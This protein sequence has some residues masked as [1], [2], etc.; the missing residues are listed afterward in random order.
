MNRYVA[1]IGTALILEF[2]APTVWGLKVSVPE[3]RRL[4]KIVEEQYPENVYIGASTAFQNL[5]QGEG[6]ILNREFSYITPTN[7]FK[8]PLIHPEPGKWRW[9]FPDGWVK[10]AEKNGQLIRMHAPISPQC[11]SWAKEDSRTAEELQNNLEEY[12]TALC[13]RYNGK[14]VIR[15]LDVVNETISSDGTW[16]GPRTGTNGWENPWLKI[17]LEKQIPSKFKILSRDGVPHYI[18]RAFE[19]ANLYAPDVKLIINQH[20]MIEPEAAEK[21]KELVLYLRGRGLRVDGVGWQAHLKD[22]EP[23]MDKKGSN[24]KVLAGL[25]NWAHQNHLDFLVTENNI[26][27]PSDSPYDAEAVATV[28]ENMVGTL[29]SKRGTG[30]VAWNLWSIS[31]KPHYSQKNKWVLGLWDQD[32]KPQEAYYRIQHLLEKA[33]N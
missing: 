16:F 17:G 10:S 9:D 29:I 19:L 33:S 25:I 22:M 11:S 21:L 31:D 7:D 2:W 20:A 23:W 5:N 32:F 3:G 24:L 14:P 26:H 12:V 6:I 28:F 30:V 18:I 13:R 27:V 4:R 8:Q 15:W 1:T